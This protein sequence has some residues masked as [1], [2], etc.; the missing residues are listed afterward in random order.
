MIIQK[1]LQRRF[2]VKG[3][4]CTAADFVFPHKLKD[5][6]QYSNINSTTG[7]QCS[8]AFTERWYNDIEFH[9]QTAES[10]RTIF[11]RS[12]STKL[13]EDTVQKLLLE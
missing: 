7:E 12:N 6:E 13:R 9:V 2:H 1:V 10:N 8:V 5:K 4:T 11:Y 3:N